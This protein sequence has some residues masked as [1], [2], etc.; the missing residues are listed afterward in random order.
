M[1]SLL[2]SQI[3]N[4]KKFPIAPSFVYAYSCSN[5]LNILTYYPDYTFY[6]LKNDHNF[7][8]NLSPHPKKEIHQ[9][10]LVNKQL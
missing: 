2:V 5:K 9:N 3:M 10:H 8:R 7:I 6:K 4:Y 1:I